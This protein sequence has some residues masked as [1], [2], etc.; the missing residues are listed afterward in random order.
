MIVCL[1]IDHHG[2]PNRLA[3][4]GAIGPGGKTEVDLTSKYVWAAE[5]V[6]RKAGCRVCVVSSDFYSKRWAFSDSIGAVCYVSC[7]MNAGGGDRGEV[8]YDSRSRPGG[9]SALAKCIAQSLSDKVPWGAEVKGSGEGENQRAFSCIKGLR[10]IGIVYEPGFL[11]G[12]RGDLSSHCK[13]MGRALA[14]GIITYSWSREG[15]EPRLPRTY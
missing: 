13:D 10:G 12:P 2:K 15:P 14:E 7:H 5:K 8:Y 4:R 3:D 1:S 6:L 11:D 9:G